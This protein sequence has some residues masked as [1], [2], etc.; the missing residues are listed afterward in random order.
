[1]I[2]ECCEELNLRVPEDISVIGNDNVSWSDASKLGL[3][4]FEQPV[5]ETGKLAINVLC[6]AIENNTQVQSKYLLSKLIE[7]TSVS[8]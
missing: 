6:D 5:L 3:T 7:R 1:M 2:F 4:S 8:K